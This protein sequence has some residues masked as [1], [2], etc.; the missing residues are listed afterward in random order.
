[1]CVYMYKQVCVCVPV[2]ACTHTHTR[3]CVC[4][5][6]WVCTHLYMSSV[7]HRL[8]GLR[9]CSPTFLL[10]ISLINVTVSV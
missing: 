3:A 7:H 5:S 2:R 1:M 6:E 9:F 4:V 8:A 10:I